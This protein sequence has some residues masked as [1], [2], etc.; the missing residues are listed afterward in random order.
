MK[1]I[2]YGRSGGRPYSS[3]ETILT[4]LPSASASQEESVASVC[5][6]TGM[7]VDAIHAWRSRL[8]RLARE[9]ANEIEA[10]KEL[11]TGKR[12]MPSGSAKS[13]RTP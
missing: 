8:A 10:E 3:I 9:I 2:L 12:D 1:T 13:V 7:S 11:L 4:T 6:S 5:D